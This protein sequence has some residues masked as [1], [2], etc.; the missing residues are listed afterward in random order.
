MS[1]FLAMLSACLLVHGQYD[2]TTTSYDT[3][4]C[5]S[6]MAMISRG[7]SGY[8][9]GGKGVVIRDIYDGLQNGPNIGAPGTFWSN[10]IF[11][12]TKMYP[13]RVDLDDATVTDIYNYASV[14]V[15]VGSAMDKLLYD[16][17]NLQATSWGWGVFYGHD[18]NSVDIRC[19][20]LAS[21]DK[22]DCPG[23]Y[24]P[25]GGVFSAD[26]SAL[27]TGGYPVGNPYANPEWGGGAGCHFDGKSTI[28][29]LNQYD[30]N[31]NNLVQDRD[32]QCNY[33]FNSN[34]GDWV[35]LY[36]SNQDYDD[37]ELHGDRG[38]CWVNNIRDMI[39]IQNWL[40]WMRA[41]WKPSPGLFTGSDE[42][43]YM[44]WNEVP[45][46]RTVID[47]PSNW[48]AFIIKLPAAV[49]ND[50]GV[51]DRIECLSAV[52]LTRLMKR[53]DQYVAGGSLFLG[54]EYTATRPGSYSLVVKEWKDSTNNWFLWFFCQNWQNSSY[55]YK[56]VF[57]QK[58]VN[59]SQ[60]GE[61]YL[62][63][64]GTLA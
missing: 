14:G 21:E 17:D 11:S 4:V 42:R 10:D 35:S 61:C 23:G 47:D 62:D 37:W 2:N 56:M 20:W 15:V 7:T 39:S 38:I 48:D 50:E 3:A 9:T 51:S 6:L 29:Q 43:D 31:G 19:R 12:V 8:Y 22:Y 26:T 60:N 40:F 28:D 52:K 58:D 5:D 41:Y 49:C 53:I 63:N 13:D 1:R 45:F 32:C 24:I 57:L 25:W 44:G 33:N 36:A 46:S 59:V 54:S 16:F 27:G 18:S 55:K 64:A 30:S 34:W